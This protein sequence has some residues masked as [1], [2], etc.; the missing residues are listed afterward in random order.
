M[1]EKLSYGLLISII[2]I[3]TILIAGCS[4]SSPT[5]TTPVPT[6]A[7]ANKFAA[8]DIIAKSSTSTEQPL[9]VILAYDSKKDMY[10]RAFVYK[11]ADGSWGHRV[12]I[13]NE[14]VPRSLVEKVYPAKITHVALTSVPIVATT[15][16]TA[17]PTTY[18]GPAPS[19]D[20]ISPTSGGTDTTIT[21]TISGS[22]FQSG[23]TAKLLRGGNPV[24]N[25]A[26]V[27][28]I[29][30]T[31]TATF[32]L[33]SAEAGHYNVIVINPDGQTDTLIGGF[34]VGEA[35]PIITGVYPNTGAIN[36]T[37]AL[38]INGQNFG[39]LAKVSFTQGS[40]SIDG[41]YTTDVIAIDSTKVTLNLQIPAGTPVGDWD[42]SVLN[43]ATQGS[44]TWNQKFH[45]TNSTA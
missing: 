5:T 38:T 20:K 15:I 9:Y 35:A 14:T 42:V 1:R 16:P 18:S 26:A 45:I 21:M 11:N 22:N 4:S 3:A 43:V 8:G 41:R 7:T 34:T 25:G 33:Q 29:S 36:G 24:I 2:L 13:R 10:T 37:V 39:D 31:V 30:N 44:G 40:S 6:T 23:A 12:D 19:I 32:N 27:S 28:A 17:V